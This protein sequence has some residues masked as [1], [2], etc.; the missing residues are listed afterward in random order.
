M[1]IVNLTIGIQNEHFYGT[2]LIDID[3]IVLK[4][5][6]V[7]ALGILNSVYHKVFIDLTCNILKV[8]RV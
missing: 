8:M 4:A 2:I 7:K 5:R 1:L 3:Q 6:I